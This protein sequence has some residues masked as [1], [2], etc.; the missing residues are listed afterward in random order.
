MEMDQ[1]EAR[2]IT[3]LGLAEGSSVVQLERLTGLR[4]DHSIPIPNDV[5]TLRQSFRPSKRPTTPNPDT[6]P[7]SRTCVLTA[8]DVV[9]YWPAQMNPTSTVI[10]GEGKVTSKRVAPQEQN[11][12]E[13][14]SYQLASCRYSVPAHS[15][16]GP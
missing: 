8:F 2:C 12:S 13:R 1:R 4:G 15:S 16:A 7:K 3:P 11:G 14:Y 9:R 6:M 10:G 5:H